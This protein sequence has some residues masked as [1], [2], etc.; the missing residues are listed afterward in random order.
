MS[1]IKDLISNKKQN[2]FPNFNPNIKAKEKN[3]QTSRIHNNPNNLPSSF[4]STK[5]TLFPINDVLEHLKS[6]LTHP[7]SCYDQNLVKYKASRSVG[8]CSI[9][10]HLLVVFIL[11]W[12]QSNHRLELRERNLLFMLFQS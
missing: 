10:D 1:Y 9:K 6:E 5:T 8:Q 12:P 7:V 4:S 2:P 11:C 3:T